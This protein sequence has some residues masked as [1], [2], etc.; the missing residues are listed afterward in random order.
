MLTESD[1]KVLTDFVAESKRDGHAG[2]GETTLVM[3]T[4]PELVRLD[5]CD[6]ESGLSTHISDPLTSA[7]IKWGRSWSK[8]FPN[9]YNGH[10]P[11]GLTQTIADAAVEIAV[12][13]TV[14]ALKILKD[15]ELMHSIIG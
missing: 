4:Y 12:Q 3:G 6:A 2:F 7:E 9:A 13:R 10:P 11:Y 14:K 1:M 8:N 15:D 5:R